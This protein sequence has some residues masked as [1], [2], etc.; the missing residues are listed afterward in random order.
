MQFVASG[1]AGLGEVGEQGAKG[2][3][4]GG[5]VKEVQDGLDFFGGLPAGAG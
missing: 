2:G 1:V 4:V 3:M 5:V